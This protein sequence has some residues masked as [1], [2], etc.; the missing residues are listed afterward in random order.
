MSQHSELVILGTSSGSS[1]ISRSTSGS[2][3]K[4][5]RKCSY[6]FDPSE[7]ISLRIRTIGMKLNVINKIF[8]THAHQDHYLGLFSL[9]SEM[10]IY[11]K[12]KKVEVILPSILIPFVS[13]YLILSKKSQNFYDFVKLINIE[14]FKNDYISIIKLQHVSVV[15]SF[16]F[17]LRFIQPK[18][19]NVK[20]LKS[21]DIPRSEFGKFINNENYLIKTKDKVLFYCGDN[22][23]LDIIEHVLG[24]LVDD[25]VTLYHE[26][27]YTT[28][29]FNRLSSENK[30][31][32]HT[33][34]YQVTKMIGKLQKIQNIKFIMSHFSPRIKTV[35]EIL[36][37][38]HIDCG[39]EIAYDGYRTLL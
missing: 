31:H 6:L 37:D 32:G 24:G 34:I 28:K 26:G 25:N 16:G 1:S 21:E 15:D 23:N 29:I 13:D 36:D 3:L 35:Q 2:L 20:L 19:L 33:S 10:A 27:T 9:L 17:V 22:E 14:N 11:S 30:T 4:I 39:V 38:S 7:G 8:I 5:N 18:K 12:P